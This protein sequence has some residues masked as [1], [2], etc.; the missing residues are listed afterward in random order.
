MRRRVYDIIIIVIIVFVDI[1]ERCS[2]FLRWTIADIGRNPPPPPP[3]TFRR[4]AHC[5]VCVCRVHLAY[6][7]HSKQARAAAAAAL[8]Q[9]RRAA[10]AA[11]AVLLGR[12][13]RREADTQLVKVGHVRAQVLRPVLTMDNPNA[14]RLRGR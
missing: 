12:R 13:K 3:R 9:C 5:R 10:A 7:K 6:L 14:T 2:H 8:R 11:A 1:V 4:R